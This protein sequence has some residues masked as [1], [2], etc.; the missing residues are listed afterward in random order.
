MKLMVN[1]SLEQEAVVADRLTDDQIA[2][3]RTISEEIEVVIATSIE[4]RNRELVDADALFG[5]FNPQMFEH[6][7]KLRWVQSIG[8]GVDHMMY[9]EFV[10]S[11]IV[12]TSAKG[13]VGTHLAD[14][15][16]ALLLGVLRGVG[17]AVRERS[18]DSR[19]SIRSESWELGG[20]TMGII[21]LGGTGVEVARR[22]QGFEMRVI[23]IDRD[24]VP[25]P[26]FVEE[27]WTLAR[28]YDLLRESDV[29]MICAPLTPET[30]GMFD[31]EAF[32]HM[33]PHAIIVNV[34]RGAI[35]DGPSL[36]KALENRTIGGAGLDVTPEEPLPADHPLWT[37][38]NAIVTPHTAGGSSLRIGRA[39]DLLCENIRRF[40]DDR[41]L[42]GV[43][44][45]QLGY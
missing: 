34:T 2:Q 33:R 45:K 36:I 44:D 27:V 32:G 18:W 16:W 9:D 11:D 22:A 10:N 41:P 35:I 3:I 43:I 30:R 23:A 6:A 29:V 25:K 28:F 24:D 13:T 1:L 20:R 42:L 40:L 19:P 38:S 37:M 21:G 14:H 5:E 7:K 15:A 17:R 31:D 12:L 8:S 4:Q 26:D 39:V